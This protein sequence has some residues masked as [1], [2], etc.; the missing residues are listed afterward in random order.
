M[1]NPRKERHGEA[2]P[3]MPLAPQ[4]MPSP[5]QPHQPNIASS[6]IDP[7]FPSLPRF[8]LCSVKLF[9]SLLLC[10]C[11]CEKRECE[12]GGVESGERFGF[13]NGNKS[14]DNNMNDFEVVV[15]AT[16][17]A[18]RAYRGKM[19]KFSLMSWSNCVNHCL[20]FRYVLTPNDMKARDP[21]C[22]A[23]IVLPA[24]NCAF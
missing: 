3:E 14:E 21:R 23:P 4:Q 18:A 2:T 7:D 17:V 24:I 8:R 22:Q 15:E 9:S 5:S 20:L 10:S 1:E 12:D 19:K 11:C 16:M 13:F 6:S